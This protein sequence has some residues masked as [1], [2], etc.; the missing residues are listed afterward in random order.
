MYKKAGVMIK[1]LFHRGNR[2]QTSM[3][4]K[5]KRPSEETVENKREYSTVSPLKEV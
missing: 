2:K 1:D 5:N 3:K 4:T